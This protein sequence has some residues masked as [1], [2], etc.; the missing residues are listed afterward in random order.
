MS[1]NGKREGFGRNDCIALGSVAGIKKAHADE[2][3][4]HVI[5]T[6]HRWPDFAEKAGVSE[7][8]M[9]EIQANLR[10]SL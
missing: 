9:T 4:T 8:R 2:M 3:V 7:K 1:L 10:T 5:E 6:M